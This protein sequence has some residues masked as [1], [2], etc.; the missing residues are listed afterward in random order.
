M[1]LGGWSVVQHEGESH[2]L[3]EADIGD[4]MVSR[5]CHCKPR[6]DERESSV[7]IHNSYDQRESYENGRK[8][9]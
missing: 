1:N 5:E 2:I 3:P 9:Q 7:I 6:E 8:L 4:H